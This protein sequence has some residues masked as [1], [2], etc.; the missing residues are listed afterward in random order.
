MEKALLSLQ[1][2]CYRQQV[3]ISQSDSS[4]DSDKNKLNLHCLDNQEDKCAVCDNKTKT[5]Y[6]HIEAV[7]QAHKVQHASPFTKLHM[8]D[9]EATY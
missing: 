6:Y 1:S 7:P 3:S 5:S 9:R 8:R 2:A 4:D